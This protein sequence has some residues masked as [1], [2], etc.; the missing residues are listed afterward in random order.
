MLELLVVGLCLNG[1]GCSSAL[2]GYY[3]SRPALKQTARDGRRYVASMVGE[4]TMVALLPVVALATGGQASIR[5]GR[6]WTIKAGSG[7]TML[8]FGYT[9]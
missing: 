7:E 9:F 1:S 5:L 3:A 2:K 6:R 4:S 8:N